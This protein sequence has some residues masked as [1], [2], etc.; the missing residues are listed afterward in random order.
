M[1]KMRTFANQKYIYNMFEDF[2]KFLSSLNFDI[3]NKSDDSIAFSH[4]GLNYLFVYDNNDP[5]YLR[6][7]LPNVINV[8]DFKDKGDLNSV[9]ND[10][11]SKFKTVK[12]I[13]IG[14]SLWFAIEQFVYSKD[15]NSLNQ[16]FSRIISVLETVI[17]NFRSDFLQK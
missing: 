7:L 10:Y 5:Y 12:L 11:N 16:L 13:I 2:Y 8:E 9:I 17:L 4:N 14:N 1:K 15:D 6:L 3:T